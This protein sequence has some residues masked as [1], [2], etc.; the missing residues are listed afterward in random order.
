M[1]KSRFYFGCWGVGKVEI[2]VIKILST[3]SAQTFPQTILERFK[4]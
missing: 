3:E 2:S 1:Q 4:T